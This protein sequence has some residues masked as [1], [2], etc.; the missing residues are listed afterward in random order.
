[1]LQ[2]F[3]ESDYLK[4]SYDKEEG[5]VF[6]DWRRFPLSPEFRVWNE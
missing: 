1:M 2:K 5:Y 6:A 3:F 4:L